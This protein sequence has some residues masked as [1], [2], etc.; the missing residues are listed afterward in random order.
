MKI[1][2]RKEYWCL[3]KARMKGSTF[4]NTGVRQEGMRI[5]LQVWQWDTDLGKDT[6]IGQLH[7]TQGLFIEAN[8]AAHGL[9][10]QGADTNLFHSRVCQKIIKYILEILIHDFSLPHIIK[11]LSGELFVKSIEQVLDDV[12]FRV[13]TAPAHS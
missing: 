8:I 9:V 11:V 2:L 4:R 3:K 5:R 1:R 7:N 6:Q 12:L 10:D 13:G